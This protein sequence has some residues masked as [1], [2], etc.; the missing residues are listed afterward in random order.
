MLEYLRCSAADTATF[1]RK[2]FQFGTYKISTHSPLPLP[3]NVVALVQPYL[4]L[5]A[6]AT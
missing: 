1:A 5:E 4:D 6:T 2:M 3:S